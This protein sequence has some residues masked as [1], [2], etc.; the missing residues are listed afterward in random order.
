MTQQEFEEMYC[1]NSK[2][3]LEFLHGRGIFAYPCSCGEDGCSGWQM[4]TKEL[5]EARKKMGLE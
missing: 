4:Q 5:Y 2:V 3:T 1:R